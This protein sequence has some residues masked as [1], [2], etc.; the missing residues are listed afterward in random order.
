MA[1]IQIDEHLVL[2][3]YR[4]ADADLLFAAIDRERKHLGPWL[5]WVAHTTRPKHSLDF[6]ELSQRQILDQQ[7]L[8]LGIFYDE[9]IIGGIGMH[10]WN[11]DTKCAQVGYWIAKEHEGKGIVARSVA[12]LLDYLF[13]A[14]GINKAEIRFVVAN[15]RSAALANRLGFKTEGILRQSF[16][17]NGMVED[18]V[19]TGILKSEWMQRQQ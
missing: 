6:I 10:D 18:L 13:E 3:P 4:S 14:V 15:K 12:A 16:I 19:V 5:G 8:P 17:R 1:I 9:D 2:R 11:R 7:A